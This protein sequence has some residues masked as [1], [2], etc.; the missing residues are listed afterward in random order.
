MSPQVATLV[1]AVGIIV[2]FVLDRDPKGRTSFALSIPMIWLAIG[3]SRVVSQ[4]LN[5]TEQ[6]SASAVGSAYMEG[7]PIDRTIQAVLMMIGMIVLVRRSQK[8]WQ[9]L[10]ANGPILLF[11]L[12]CGSS[13]LWSDFPEVAFRRWIKALGDLIM[14][15][16]VLTDRDRSAALKLPARVGFLLIPLSILFMKYYPHLARSFDEIGGSEYTGVATSKNSLGMVCLIFGLGSVWRFLEA[17]RSQDRA[18]R[19]GKLVAH[20]TIIVLAMWLFLWAH[21]MTSLFCFIFAVGL[22]VATGFPAVAR[23]PLKFHALVAVVLL[24]SF[25]VLFLGVGGGL[26]EAV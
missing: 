2:L 19:T 14:V 6:A 13:T 16:V 17:Y 25:A 10:R 1:F 21:S 5:P 23:S 7:N 4:W 15:L 20:G 3:G 8:L 24:G 22:V 26:L 11:L 9:L 18:Q 12:Y